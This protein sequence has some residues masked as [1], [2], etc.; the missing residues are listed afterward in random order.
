M[1]TSESSSTGHSLKVN[2]RPAVA[3]TAQKLQPGFPKT[4]QGEILFLHQ[5]NLNTD[6]IYAGKWTYTEVAPAQQAEVAMENYDPNFKSLARAGDIIVGGY[7]FG[8]G[9]SREQAVTSLKHKGIGLILAGSFSETYTRNAWNN[10]FV[11]IEVPELAADFKNRFGSSE[12][13]VRTGVQAVVDFENCVVKV[14]GKSYSIAT[15]GKI[16]QELVIDG[17]LENWVKNQAA[18]V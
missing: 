9:S 3:K 4:L 10:G 11:C 16:V 14:D 18:K 2:G 15:L 12:P 6:G 5:D 13:T 1:M 8:T 7:N 17:G